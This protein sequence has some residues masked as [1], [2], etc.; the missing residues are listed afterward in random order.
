MLTKR[1]SMKKL[2]QVLR[3]GLLCQNGCTSY[4]PKPQAQW[5][6][7]PKDLESSQ[8][9]RFDLGR[10]REIG[11]CWVS[12]FILSPLRQPTLRSIWATRLAGITPRVEPKGVTK[13]LL[14]E[15]YV[16]TY[17]NRSCS[18]SQYCF[19]YFKW[20]KKQKRSMRQ[21]HKAGEKLFV[22][23]ALQWWFEVKLNS[24]QVR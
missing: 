21:V 18:Y 7:D 12:Q 9:T 22:D 14:W 6:S 13:H 4:S 16:Q 8:K 15:E 20:V 17:H 24:H 5:R 2:R 23:Y 3:L 19:L 10:C 11:W 1:I